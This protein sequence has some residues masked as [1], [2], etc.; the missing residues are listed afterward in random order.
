[1]ED[2]VWQGWSN[3]EIAG[4]CGVSGHTVGNHRKLI[5][6]I[7]NDMKNGVRKATR[8]GKTY[9]I[10]TSNIGKTAEST[11]RNYRESI[12]AKCVDGF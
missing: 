1:M 4:R 10:D 3:Y 2:E 9:T 5:I 7:F 11:I 12:Y 8:N 6:E